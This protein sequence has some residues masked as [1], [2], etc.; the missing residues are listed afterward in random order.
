MQ[1]RSGLTWGFAALQALDAAVTEAGFRTGNWVEH[2][3]LV[4]RHSTADRM[5]YFGAT[6]AAVILASRWAANHGHYK[7][8]IA[9][10]VGGIAVEAYASAHSLIAFPH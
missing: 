1:L 5:L 10:L 7:T 2:N 6:G 9:I 3:P 8:A 4:P